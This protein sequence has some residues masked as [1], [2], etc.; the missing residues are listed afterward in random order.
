MRCRVCY[1][2][3]LEVGAQGPSLDGVAK[4]RS[5]GTGTVIKCLNCKIWQ[6]DTALNSI[7]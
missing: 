6:S 1:G 5:D 4:K 3:T 2:D 7:Y